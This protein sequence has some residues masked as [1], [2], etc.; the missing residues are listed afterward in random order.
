MSLPYSEKYFDIFKSSLYRYARP[1][2]YVKM[3]GNIVN[4]I[5]IMPYQ[6]PSENA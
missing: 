6:M 2:R 3:H 5:K 1:R 4:K